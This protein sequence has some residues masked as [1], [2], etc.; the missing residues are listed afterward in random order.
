MSYTSLLKNVNQGLTTLAKKVVYL[1][2][3]SVIANASQVRKVCPDLTNF[4]GSEQIF[5][6]TADKICPRKNFNKIDKI[7]KIMLNLSIIFQKT[8][9]DLPGNKTEF[10]LLSEAII[11]FRAKR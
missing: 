8:Y 10:N 4:V 9:R 6:R 1:D 7:N 11:A 5:K 3:F 2:K